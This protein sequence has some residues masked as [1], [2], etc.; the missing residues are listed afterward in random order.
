MTVLKRW[1]QWDQR[2]LTQWR[3]NVIYT[4]H[5]D[6]VC[7]SHRILTA[8]IP[9]TKQLMPH[10]GTIAVHHTN[11]MEQRSIVQAK[12]R[13]PYVKRDVTYS[14]ANDVDTDPSDPAVRQGRWK[15]GMGAKGTQFY[16]CLWILS[17][18]TPFFSHKAAFWIP[19][20]RS[21]SN[22]ANK[23]APSR[24]LRHCS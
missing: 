21:G 4:L 5:E 6:S 23:G 12:C 1:R 17:N 16:K 2:Y 20:T 11:Y 3:W 14:A 15:G 13:A 9:K 18:W 19:V 24:Y 7:A 10:W 8:Y 22:F